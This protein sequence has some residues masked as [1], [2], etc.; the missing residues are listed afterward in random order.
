MLR[1]IAIASIVASLA[2]GSLVALAGPASANNFAVTEVTD[3]VPEVR[4]R[5]VDAGNMLCANDVA[6]DDWPVRAAVRKPNGDL[7]FV[8]DE[9]PGD[10]P[11]CRAISVRENVT[12]KIKACRQITPFPD[13][14]YRCSPFKEG[15]S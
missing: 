2:T 11:T 7:A 13:D 4:A 1:P 12:I 3:G 10:G 5:W 15:R 8:R 9:I 14:E 6:F